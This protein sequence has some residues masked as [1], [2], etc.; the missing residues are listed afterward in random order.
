MSL[1]EI[2][3]LKVTQFRSILSNRM[4]NTEKHFNRSKSMVSN[5]DH[6]I[7]ACTFLMQRKLSTSNDLTHMS[8]LMDIIRK[9]MWFK[10][11]PNR[12]GSKSTPESR[13][14][15]T[16]NI[17][18]IFRFDI[19]VEGMIVLM[20]AF[21]SA[22][23]KCE[24]CVWL[25]VHYRPCQRNRQCT[26]EAWLIRA[27]REIMPKS[28]MWQPSSYAPYH[29]MN[30]NKIIASF[31]VKKLKSTIENEIEL[32]FLS[33][34]HTHTQISLFCHTISWNV[35]F[36]FMILYVQGHLQLKFCATVLCIGFKS[37]CGAIIFKTVCENAPN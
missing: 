36:V 1:S 2:W 28:I 17:Y 4:W 21:N 35:S 13:L 11:Q 3:T 37:K 27:A 32:S 23:V 15:Y 34:T 33:A 19:N 25:L 29:L 10:F 14:Q 30:T 8:E 24:F 16:P 31:S 20:C 9:F 5:N 26:V 18:N 22:G 6:A 7:E 12:C